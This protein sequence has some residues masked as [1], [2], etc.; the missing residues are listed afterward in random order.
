M[1]RLF[2]A[3]AR[4]RR[5]RAVAIAAAQHNQQVSSSPAREPA[6]LTPRSSNAAA[7]RIRDMLDDTVSRTWV[8]AGDNLGYD[9][10]QVKRSYPELISDYVRTK[11]GRKLDAIIDLTIPESSIHSLRDSVEWRL[12]KFQP[13]VVC[14]MPGLN[15]FSAGR[16]GVDAF[17]QSIEDLAEFLEHEGTVMVLC[18]PPVNLAAEREP[19]HESYVYVQ[20]IRNCAAAFGL[21]LIDHWKY[22]QAAQKTQP[23]QDWA[24]AEGTQ[25]LLEGH[26]RLARHTLRSLG[27]TEE[28]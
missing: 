24:T 7:A 10:S 25:L 20:A 14:L 17:M 22:W 2:S 16:E 27:V 28:K 5:R 13:D 12:A 26:K 11:L 3:A 6:P 18:T 15:D 23:I 8:F 21:V 19:H 1:S 9:P 4:N